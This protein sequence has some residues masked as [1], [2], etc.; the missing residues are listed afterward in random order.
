VQQALA[1]QRSD[2][3]VASL[4]ADTFV[5]PT[6]CTF[7]LPDQNVERCRQLGFRIAHES[8]YLR[9]RG[10]GQVSVMGDLDAERIWPVFDALCGG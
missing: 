10:W 2:G 9:E 3:R 5:A 8:C 4:E 7:P 1:R 6:I